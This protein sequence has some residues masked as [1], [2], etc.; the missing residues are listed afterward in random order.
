MPRK[1]SVSNA[2]VWKTAKG[3]SVN[4]DGTAWA[5]PKK[6]WGNQ[7]GVWKQCWPPS[8]V[9]F[10]T[11]TVS[12]TTGALGD[13]PATFTWDTGWNVPGT[14]TIQR[15]LPSMTDFEDWLT[16]L[17]LRGT[18]TVDP[19]IVSG[20]TGNYQYRGVYTLTYSPVGPP[21]V[22]L[23]FTKNVFLQPV[24]GVF[25]VA[26]TTGEV[27]YG[28]SL[29]SWSFNTTKPGTARLHRL[30]LG[31]GSYGDETV[32]ASG[33]PS[34][35]SGTYQL[36]PA[37]APGVSQ[38]GTWYYQAEWLP[39]SGGSTVTAEDSATLTY[40]ALGT[41]P[42]NL[43]WVFP[44]NDS[45][46]WSLPWPG[47]ATYS[48]PV[49]IRIPVGSYGTMNYSDLA[50]IEV[51]PRGVDGYYVWYDEAPPLAYSFA[52]E[53]TG[54]TS[55]GTFTGPYTQTSEGREWMH[56]TLTYVYWIGGWRSMPLPP[57][58]TY[59]PTVPVGFNL[60]N[61]DPLSGSS[62]RAILT[63]KDGQVM[64]IALTSTLAVG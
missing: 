41:S 64:T 58:G 38:A 53:V 17:P 57:A 63:F 12:I 61:S 3:L 22:A 28:T 48:D 37:G 60:L 34:S 56:P 40:R 9:T 50:S 13:T 24:S 2:G 30:K 11:F 51:R 46:D 39:A 8:V 1:L 36:A 4:Y 10:D 45:E 6:A 33:L 25:A 47:P 16:G 55:T 23:S 7:G 44:E 52:Y 31:S 20:S 18:Q 59:G 42:T 26:A 5:M 62:G 35:G 14:V 19:L 29:M 21:V 15:K 27:Y 49:G 32:F 54:G 43:E